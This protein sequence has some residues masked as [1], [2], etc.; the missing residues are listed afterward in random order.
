LRVAVDNPLPA[1][2]AT[3]SRAVLLLSDTVLEDFRVRAAQ[4]KLLTPPR[5][6]PDG[7]YAFVFPALA[8]EAE[9]RYQL[10]LECRRRAPRTLSVGLMVDG[11]KA[12]LTREPLPVQIFFA[13]QEDQPRAAVPEPL[14]H[15]VGQRPP[16][17]I[18]PFA[19]YSLALGAVVAGGCAIAL[20]AVG[21]G[22]ARGRAAGRARGRAAG[23]ARGAV[24]A[25]VAVAQRRRAAQPGRAS[26]NELGSTAGVAQGVDGRDVR[27]AGLTPPG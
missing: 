3:P 1:G 2:P 23:R 5:R 15:W 9:N 10:T 26:V 16:A 18:A 11:P 4:P 6:R 19:G 24:V 25:V 21:R 20:W 8:P 14:A 12:L 22:R 27:D 17:P 7:R 13:D